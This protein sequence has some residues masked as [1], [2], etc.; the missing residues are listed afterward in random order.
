[1]DVEQ[2]FSRQKKI[3]PLEK[4]SNFSAPMIVGVGAIGRNVAIQLAA[5]GV[6]RMTLVDFDSVE[7]SNIAS[8]GYW[9]Q[10]IGLPKVEAT[11]RICKAINSNIQIE[12]IN[13][14]FKR[15]M[16]SDIVFSCVDSISVREFI[17]K[18]ISANVKFFVDARMAAEVFRILT[19]END[20]GKC[21]Y[22][23]TLFSEAEAFV[24][25][26]TAK[27]TIYCSNIAA[28]FMVQTL[29]KWLREFPND[30][31][32]SYNLLGNDLIVKSDLD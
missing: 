21:Y 16:E 27:S 23:S 17:W 29:T 18:N 22:P 10:D 4:L 9:E 30:L 11:Q 26:C 12:V 6:E 28:G 3:V 20:I 31:D 2:R 7:E 15:G 25:T 14:K 8:Q 5:I 19:V 24:G 32:V 1:M 13:G